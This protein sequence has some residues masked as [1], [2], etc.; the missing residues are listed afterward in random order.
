MVIGGCPGAA[1]YVMW[2]R[3]RCATLPDPASQEEAELRA[4]AT[5]PSRRACSFRSMMSYGS[6]YRVLV[7]E[8][9]VQHVTFDSGVGVMNA[10][11]QGMGA[12]HMGTKVE[13]VRVGILKNIVVLN[14]GH[15]S[16]VLMVV[17]WVAKDTETGPSLLQDAHGFWLANMAARPRD[18]AKPY[19]F[20]AF[21]SQVRLRPR[22]LLSSL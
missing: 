21:A 12:A 16:I 13:L 19:L 22:V 11:P 7:E 18:V 4:I 20:P 17:S 15:M 2:L 8:G 5:R 14:Y 9:V 10:R 3:D 1:P 6:H